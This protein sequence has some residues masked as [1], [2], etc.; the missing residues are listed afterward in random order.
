MSWIACEEHMPSEREE[1]LVYCQNGRRAV[2]SWFCWFPERF[3][4]PLWHN[5]FP[6]MGD[7]VTHW[8]P[9]PAPPTD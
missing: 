6:Q 7:V 4:P 8:Q 1:V 5:M 2:S 3:D 9:L